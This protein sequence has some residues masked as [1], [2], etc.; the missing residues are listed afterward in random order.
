MGFLVRTPKSK[1]DFVSLEPGYD[2]RAPVEYIPDVAAM[3][4]RAQEYCRRI[5]KEFWDN[6]VS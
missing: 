3:R 4:E 5:G 1:D 2:F 6:E